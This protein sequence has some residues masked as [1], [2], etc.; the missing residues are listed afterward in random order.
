MSAA[1]AIEQLEQL[2]ERLARP[3]PA[4]AR[5]AE[6]AAEAT[7]E[8]LRARRLVDSGELL[9]SVFADGP[10]FGVSAPYAVYVNAKRPFVP[11][12]AGALD[13]E[14]DARVRAEIDAYVRGGD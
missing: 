1:Q 8:G 12:T 7:R 6:L 11:V 4:L 3:A 2:A 10:V 9:E 14:L 13:A 5:G